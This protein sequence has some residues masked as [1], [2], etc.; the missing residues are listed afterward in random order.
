MEYRLHAITEEQ[1]IFVGMESAYS[2]LRVDFLLCSADST[3][4]MDFA[5]LLPAPLTTH[6]GYILAVNDSGDWEITKPPFAPKPTTITGTLT[7]GSTSLVLSNAAITT[8][9]AIDIYT[10]KWGVNPSDVVV[11]AGKVTL[12]FEAQAAALN[13]KVE[14]K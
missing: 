7:A 1:A 13:V 3:W 8:D 14:V 4:T 12:T 2:D 11:V 9:S 5:F 10:D 6:K